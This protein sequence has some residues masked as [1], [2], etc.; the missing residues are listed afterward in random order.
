MALLN[1]SKMGWQN[2][3]ARFL[4]HFYARL[5][6]S[7]KA[8]AY[9][10]GASLGRDKHSSLFGRSTSDKYELKIYN[11]DD[12]LAIYSPNEIVA[13]QIKLLRIHIL[14]HPAELMVPPP[15]P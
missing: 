4:T 1:L 8:F 12:C 2:K 5:T 3:L 9:P 15:T 10:R 7:H 13:S 6:F 11:V 14:G